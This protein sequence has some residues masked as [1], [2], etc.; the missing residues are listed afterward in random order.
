MPKFNRSVPRARLLVALPVIL[1]TAFLAACGDDDPTFP[2]TAAVEDVLIQTVPQSAPFLMIEDYDD[3]I[4][5]LG[6]PVDGQ[7]RWVDVPVTWTSSRPSLVTVRDAVGADG[8]P[9]AVLHFVASPDY[10]N[11][12]HVDTITL[13]ATA[14]GRTGTAQVIVRENPRVETVAVTAISPFLPVGAVVE[15]TATPRDGFGNVIPA[16]SEW[17][18]ATSSASVASLVDNEDGTATVT[19]VG[20]GAAAI[21]AAVVNA[22]EDAETGTITGTSAVSVLPALQSGDAIT[23]GNIGADAVAQWTFTL[24]AGQTSFRVAITGSDTGDA[25]LYVYP[26]G[27]APAGNTGAG[28]VCRPFLIGSVENCVITEA[29]PG[30][31]YGIRVHAYP[32]DGPVTNLG[33][34]IV[35]PAP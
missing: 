13:T 31:T 16:P 17:E 9:R 33:L 14:G 32:D 8:R 21:T 23:V 7:R 3:E 4:T 18:W 25:D 2:S 26:P 6:V 10:V 12:T 11:P 22:G 29:T 28:F 27:F 34:T 20:Q 35:S 15:L 5:L 30:A 1:S 24:P 19:I